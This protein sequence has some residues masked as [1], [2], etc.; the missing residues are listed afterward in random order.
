MAPQ[1]KE[2]NDTVEKMKKDHAQEEKD[3]ADALAALERAVVLQRTEALAKRDAEHQAA[4][5]ALQKEVEDLRLQSQK[6]LEEKEQLQSK[7]KIISEACGFGG[8]K[9]EETKC[10]ARHDPVD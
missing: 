7:L 1:L 8:A 2:L 5:A 9:S 3:N 6:V 4:S 10:R